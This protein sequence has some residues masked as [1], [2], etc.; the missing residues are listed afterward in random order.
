MNPAEVLAIEV[1]RYVGEGHTTLVPRVMGLT[2]RSADVKRLGKREKKKWD[3]A[4]FFEALSAE[5]ETDAPTARRILEWAQ[6]LGLRIWWGEGA[7]WGSYYPMIDYNGMAYWTISVWTYGTIEIQFETL[8]T[9]PP[10]DDEK[11][12]WS[13]VTGLTTFQALIYRARELPCD[14]ESISPPY[15][16]SRFCNS[17]STC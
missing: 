10:F 7:T 16:E 12:E 13:C 17:F 1:K 3:E 4:S 5:H 9:R 2:A 11:N 6:K 14:Q 8:K 15:K